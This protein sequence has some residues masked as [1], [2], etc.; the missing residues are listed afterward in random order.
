LPFVSSV[1]GERLDGA[2]DWVDY[3]T[4]HIRQTVLY[5]PALREVLQGDEPRVLLEVGP[6]QTLTTLAR[7]MTAGSD[8]DGRRGLLAQT[9]R[10]RARMP[11]AS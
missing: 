11:S 6:S 3:W 9:H 2:V 8:R 4:R 7:A 5:G 10:K 1:T